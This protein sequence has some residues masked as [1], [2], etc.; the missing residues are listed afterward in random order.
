MRMLLGSSNSNSDQCSVETSHATQPIHESVA[1]SSLIITSFKSS[2][3]SLWPVLCSI[4][5]KK[6]SAVCPVLLTYGKSEP[7]DNICRG[8]YRRFRIHY[9]AR[10]SIC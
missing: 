9:G 4:A 7:D 6:P 2:Q 5:N 1:S 8:S 10:D 3:E